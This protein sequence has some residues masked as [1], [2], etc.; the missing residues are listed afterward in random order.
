MK[1]R[2]WPLGTP[3]RLRHLLV[4]GVTSRG[5][6]AQVKAGDV[7]DQGA[8]FSGIWIELASPPVAAG[9]RVDVEGVPSDFFGE[10]QLSPPAA[11]A[12][13]VTSSGEAPPDPVLVTPAEVGSGGAR[14]ALLEGVLVRVSGVTV[15][16]AAPLPGAGD[17]APTN[18][19]T[20]DGALR[21]DDLLHLVSPFPVVGL[22]FTELTGVLAFRQGN[23]KLEPR[24]AADLVA[25]PQLVG[26]GP[27]PAFLRAGA[28]GVPTIPAPL[29]VTLS[30]PAAADTF[31][32]V[33][34]ADT[35]ILT[36]PN[37]G[38]TVPAGV[39]SAPVLLSAGLAASPGVTLTAT[40]GAASLQAS[41]R[42]LDGTE[43]PA[44]VGL[45]PSAQSILPGG[46]ATLTATLDLP[47][48]APVEVTLAVAPAGA[49]S[50]PASVTVPADALQASF[51]CTDAAGAG[52]ATVTA[53]LGA[54]QR[55]A[56]MGVVAN[57]HLV[58][59]EVDYDG[60]G[61]DLAEF[62]EISNPTAAPV[63]LA[64]LWLILVN[65]NGSVEYDHVDLTPAGTL[66]PGQYLVICSFAVTPAPGAAVI[67][68]TA[69]G[70]ADSNAIQNGSPDGVAL[71]DTA[72]QTI[73]DALSYE[74]AITA[75][76]FTSPF[77]FL[78][79]FNLVEGTALPFGVADS[80]TLPGSLVRLPDG[81]DT[82]NA[83]VDWKFTGTPTPGAANQ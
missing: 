19:F 23:S 52:T 4:T 82:D 27:V 50:C 68:W 17:V 31:V 51:T 33:T 15:T 6:F 77:Q 41:V 65:G 38:V 40:L 25:P 71:F 75:A 29:V 72:T 44:L 47:A 10:L 42:V 76:T 11:T 81:A 80:N 63:S 3:V 59:N 26:L 58:I 55:A 43:V 70:L 78:G 64:G 32:A 36:V 66:A 69:A 60:V 34:S 22:G 56:T 5:F 83:T 35:G 18:E 21:V 2:A 39:S 30:S 74:G 53:T 9:D 67:R 13:S 48:T 49:L 57:D 14:A 16:D 62:V 61:T 7:A 79:P 24:G 37:G 20:V 46:T 8:D 54:D 73:V 12:V 28:S 45:V 1:S